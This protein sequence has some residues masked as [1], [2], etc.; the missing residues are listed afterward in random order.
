MPTTVVIIL[1]GLPRGKTTKNNLTMADDDSSG[2]IKQRRMLDREI[3]H[4]VSRVRCPSHGARS[5]TYSY[6]LILKLYGW[7]N[8]TS[9]LLYWS[10]IYLGPKRDNRG[11]RGL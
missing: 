10:Y 1:L 6:A 4:F 3:T 5:Y 7:L 2:H 9:L 8:G 11:K